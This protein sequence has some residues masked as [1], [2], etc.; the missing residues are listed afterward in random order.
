MNHALIYDICLFVE[1]FDAHA[2][3]NGLVHNKLPLTGRFSQ[4]FQQLVGGFLV[5]IFGEAQPVPAGFE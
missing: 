5:K 4:K 1:R 3:A 2:F